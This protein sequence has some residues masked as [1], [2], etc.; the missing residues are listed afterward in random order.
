MTDDLDDLGPI[1]YLVVEFPGA[2]LRGE[3]LPILLDLVDRGIV[4][5]LD[6]VFLRKDPDGSVVVLEISDLDGDG[7]LDFEVLRGASSGV[8]GRADIDQ[9]E[10][11]H[12]ARLFAGHPRHVD[13]PD[14]PVREVRCTGRVGGCRG[15]GR[16]ADLEQCSCGLPGMTGTANPTRRDQ[17]RVTACSDTVGC[18]RSPTTISIG[19]HVGAAAPVVGGGY[20][21]P[22]PPVS[23]SSTPEEQSASWRSPRPDARTC[24]LTISIGIGWSPEGTA[25]YLADSGTHRSRRPSDL[26]RVRRPRSLHPV[27]HHRPTRAGPG[28]PGAPTRCRAHL[29]HRRLGRQRPRMR[30]VPR[31]DPAILTNPRCHVSATHLF[32]T[33][34]SATGKPRIVP[35][36]STERIRSAGPSQLSSDTTH[37][38]S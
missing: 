6:L 5:I 3:A 37:T 10:P 25:M 35:G 1:D 2:R 29:P 21:V 8:L 34:R 26:L 4:R 7:V 16:R 13:R 23:C 17:I 31:P 30:P 11:D 33:S 20:L 27:R 32:A 22:Q 28:E 36:T 18:S 14:Q 19:R 12:R 38:R 15:A 24:G 9:A